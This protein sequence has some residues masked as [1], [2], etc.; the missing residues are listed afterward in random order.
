MG[1]WSHESFGNDDA[2][3]WVVEL[4][5]TDD[6]EFIAST[7]DAVLAIGDEYLQAP[8]ASQ[9]IAAAEAVARLQGNFDKRDTSTEAL[10]EW[11]ARVKLVP[12]Q[13]LTQKAHQALDRILQ[14]PSE[15]LELWSD[16]E[17]S[18]SWTQAVK[19]LKGRI[20]T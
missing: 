18:A 10:D 14:E 9:A 1:A 7:L 11:V 3:D 13:T 5:E 6:L 16:S 19:D 17:G 8:E 20:R 4:E 2:C 15:L 12:P